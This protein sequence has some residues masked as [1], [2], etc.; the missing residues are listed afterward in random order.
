MIEKWL[1]NFLITQ[2]LKKHF[3]IIAIKTIFPPQLVDS[4]TNI[5]SACF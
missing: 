5:P 2:P 3:K 1:F 4:L